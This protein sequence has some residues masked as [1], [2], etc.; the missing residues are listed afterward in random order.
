MQRRFIGAVM[1][2]ASVLTLGPVAGAAEFADTP[3]VGRIES[4]HSVGARFLLSPWRDGTRV[5]GRGRGA[6]S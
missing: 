4:L 5:D 3:E 1:V 6:A 2:L